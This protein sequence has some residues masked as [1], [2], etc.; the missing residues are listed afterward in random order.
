[1]LQENMDLRRAAILVASLDRQT[2][3]SLLDVLPS[4]KA[5][6]VRHAIMSL[7]EIDP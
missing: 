5:A 2:A 7:T 6:E 1:M 4:A 3:D